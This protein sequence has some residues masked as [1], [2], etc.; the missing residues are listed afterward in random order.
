MNGERYCWNV[1]RVVSRK[2]NTEIRNLEDLY[3]MP[4]R[5]VDTPEE[6]LVLMTTK[7]IHMT[8]RLSTCM[9]TND[10]SI[11]DSCQQLAEEIRKHERLATSGLFEQAASM[12]K[13][14]FKI[15]VRFP[16]RMERIAIMLD[17]ILDCFRIKHAEG[18]RFNDEAQEMFL[19]IF[20]AALIMLK[21][22]RD[23]LVVPNKFLLGSVK[24][25]G[26][27]FEHLVEEARL[28]NW[29]RMEAGICSPASAS[30]YVEILDCFRNVNEYIDRTSQALLDLA[31]AQPES[32][33]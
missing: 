19:A 6:H 24:H 3:E 12:G 14:M 16:S 18:L 11:M 28:A 17:N 31:R 26:K 29:E 13:Q 25:D 21:K 27:R 32:L 5:Q 10:R 30:V 8:E 22:L 20:E 1:L 9:K 4:L 2:T 7:L 33:P 23:A 15:V